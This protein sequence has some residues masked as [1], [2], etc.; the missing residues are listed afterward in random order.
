[1]RTCTWGRSALYV[2]NNWNKCGMV[3]MF[4]FVVGV[5]CRSVGPRGLAG[6]A[7]VGW[8]AGL[9]QDGSAQAPETLC[10]YVPCCVSWGRPLPSMGTSSRP[11]C[12]PPACQDA[13]LS[14]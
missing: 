7:L 10:L 3:A 6:A 5:T 8:W 1:M 9:L 12:L 13:A 2:E 4:P 11:A 14:V